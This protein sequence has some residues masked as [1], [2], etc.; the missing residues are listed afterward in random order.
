MQEKTKTRTRT[1]TKKQDVKRR[2]ELLQELGI[3]VNTYYN[4]KYKRT[5]IPRLLYPY[6]ND[7]NLSLS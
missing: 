5:P 2:N 4:Y 3:S 7:L 6:L 1:R